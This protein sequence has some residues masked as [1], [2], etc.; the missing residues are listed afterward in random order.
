MGTTTLRGDTI[1]LTGWLPWAIV[2]FYENLGVIGR[3]LR[4]DDA[5]P[6]RINNAELLKQTGQF[7]NAPKWNRINNLMQRQDLTSGAQATT[8]K[9][10]SR[11][12]AGVRLDWKMQNVQVADS[13]FDQNGITKE[14]VEMTIGQQVGQYWALELRNKCIG[15]TLA[16]LGNLTGGNSHDYSIYVPTGTKQT[17]TAQAIAS[18]LSKLGD[19]FPI[20]KSTAALIL[21]TNAWIDL[22]STQAASAATG[23][24]TPAQGGGVVATVGLPWDL[25]DD[26]TLNPVNGGNYNYLYSLIVGS[27]LID[28][29][30][31]DMKAYEPYFDRTLENPSWV[32]SGRVRLGINVNG[33][34]YDSANGGANPANAALF[35]SAYWL[36]QFS[37]HK[38][39]PVARVISNATAN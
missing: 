6:Y 18:A 24:A 2:S 13:I 39:V 10:T 19:R 15:I 17:M 38:E 14:M 21:H 33:F 32:Y 9:L 36:S 5:A 23:I 26:P 25:A 37:T 31:E 35:N 16:I 34:K 28:F 27:G 20:F 29:M 7:F 3:N 22:F 30:L 4:S 8:T 12:D 11:N 1:D